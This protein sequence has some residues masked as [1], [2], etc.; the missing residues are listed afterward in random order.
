[1]KKKKISFKLNK[2][3]N[4]F[5]M[6]CIAS[7]KAYTKKKFFIYE[8]IHDTNTTMKRKKK[9]YTIRTQ[10][11]WHSA[12]KVIRQARVK[13]NCCPAARLKCINVKKKKKKD[14]MDGVA[15]CN[16]KLKLIYKCTRLLNRVAAARWISWLYGRW[17]QRI[18]LK[19]LSCKKMKSLNE[20]EKNS[21]HVSI[22]SIRRWVD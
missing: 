14:I 12:F 20:R 22:A 13:L 2:W 7:G 5:V 17:L 18:R 10:G 16:M 1:M 9:K 8:E 3:A 21:L 19:Y 4:C 15:A 6:L 11:F